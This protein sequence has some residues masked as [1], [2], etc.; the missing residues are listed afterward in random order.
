L[1]IV[2]DD[3]T[4]SGNHIYYRKIRVKGSLGKTIAHRRYLINKLPW[5][6]AL[7]HS[8]STADKRIE[9]SDKGQVYY[10]LM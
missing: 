6:R 7:K 9:A 2:Y 1:L 3:P 8:A 10:Q 5:L 4:L